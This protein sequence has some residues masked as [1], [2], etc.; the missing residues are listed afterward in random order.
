MFRILSKPIRTVLRWQAAATALVALLAGYLAGIHG[1]IS[2]ALGG[3]VSILSGLAFAAVASLSKTKTVEG[4]LVGALRAEATKIGVI[5]VLL[6]LVFSTYEN[7]VA[8]AFIGTFAVTVIIFSMAFFVR[9]PT[10]SGKS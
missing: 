5:V 7:I 8:I 3:A 10:T 2:A 1:T 6:W 4:A 9:D